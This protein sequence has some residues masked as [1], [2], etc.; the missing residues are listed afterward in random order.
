MDGINESILNTIKKMLGITEDYTV[1]DM[2]IIVNIN[3]VFSTLIQLGVGSKE[4][5][6]IT[7]S[8]STWADLLTTEE[9]QSKF[10]FVIQYVYIQ[11]KLV[12]DPP[13]SS[14]VLDAYANRAKEL[15]WRL[16]VMEET[17]REEDNNE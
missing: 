2:D 15:E 6:V 3:S 12:F 10:S 5:F 17:F 1:F 4:G 13:A 9:E 8:L 14:F 11:V 7:D 16:N